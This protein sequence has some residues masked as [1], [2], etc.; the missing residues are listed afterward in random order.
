MFCCL[1]FSLR[2][3]S[4]NKSV[5][6]KPKLKKAA[7]SVEVKKQKPHLSAL[8]ASSVHHGLLSFVESLNS[9]TS[10]TT[11]TALTLIHFRF[12]ISLLTVLF[13]YFS[14]S[15][16]SS[17]YTSSSSS[18]FTLPSLLF[19]VLF[20][21]SSISSTS[22]P[23]F[24]VF[25]VPS[26]S[27]PAN[28]LLPSPVLLLPPLLFLLLL[29]CLILL[30]IPLFP[31]FPSFSTPLLLLLCLL[32]P[33]YGFNMWLLSHKCDHKCSYFRS[34]CV[35]PQRPLSSC[36][37]L[38]GKKSHKANEPTTA[39]QVG[40]AEVTNGKKDSRPPIHQR[41]AISN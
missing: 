20:F 26:S 7:G 4:R 18:T 35:R 33:R 29:Y 19:H 17:S 1:D 25:L 30:P 8:S 12:S 41:A 34:V 24:L 11:C 15:S 3:Q 5:K 14:F 37:L 9:C 31:T 16:S 23:V 39:T 22:T 10:S 36:K 21:F 13:L 38:L 32:L 2:S 40:F 28:P 6:R 27:S